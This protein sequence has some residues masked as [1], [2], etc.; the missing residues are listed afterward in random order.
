MYL[1]LLQSCT[2]VLLLN[3]LN[4][5]NTVCWFVFQLSKLFIALFQV[6]TPLPSEKFH[7]WFKGKK[8]F[9]FFA[10]LTLFNVPENIQL[11][12]PPPHRKSWNFLGV[13]EGFCRPNKI[14]VRGLMKISGGDG[15]RIWDKN[16]FCGRVIDIFGNYT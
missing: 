5:C 14:N 9:F 13:R 10:A 2:V 11:P 4:Y 6:Y 1:Q 16:P 7:H 3:F 12:P 15:E 8:V